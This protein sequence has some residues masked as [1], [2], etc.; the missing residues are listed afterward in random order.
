M[1]PVRRIIGLDPG[2]ATTGFAVVEADEQVANH[3]RAVDYG[4]VRTASHRHHG[5]R[6]K[7]IYD[8]LGELLRVYCPE[9]AMIEKVYFGKAAKTAMAVGEAR[10]VMVMALAER[11]V[12]VFDITPPEVKKNVVGNGRASKQQVQQMVKR[13]FGLAEVPRPPDA[14]DALAIALSGLRVAP[15]LERVEKK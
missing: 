11:G 4:V 13:I 6:L 3:Y 14:A 5:E 7:K 12:P 15:W 10:G 1:I 8:R 2:L 9:V